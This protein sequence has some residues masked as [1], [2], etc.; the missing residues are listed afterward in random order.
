MYQ[1]HGYP[2][3][4]CTEVSFANFIGQFQE[5]IMRFQQLYELYDQGTLWIRVDNL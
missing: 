2:R 3:A 4:G 5:T 1:F